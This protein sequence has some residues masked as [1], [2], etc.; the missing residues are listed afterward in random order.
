MYRDTCSDEEGFYDLLASG[1]DQ[2]HLTLR[3]SLVT[4][5]KQGSHDVIQ[6]KGDVFWKC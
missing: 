3:S 1:A 5:L 2:F 4:H 6:K